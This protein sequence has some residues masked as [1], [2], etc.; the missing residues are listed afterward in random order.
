M[1]N[2]VLDHCRLTCSLGHKYVSYK[3]PLRSS[4]EDDAFS[5]ELCFMFSDGSLQAQDA[6]RIARAAEQTG[7]QAPEASKIAQCGIH[8]AQRNILKL[9][10]GVVD[11]YWIVLLLDMGTDG[12]RIP[13][14]CAALNMYEMFAAFHDAG[15][16]Q[17]AISMLGRQGIDSISEFWEAAGR[18]SVYKKHPALQQSWEVLKKMVPLVLFYDGAE[19]FR[20]K[21]YIWFIWSSAIAQASDWDC[22]IPILCLP[23]AFVKDNETLR[24]MFSEVTRFI[25]WNL[26]ILRSGVGA[27]KGFYD[28]ELKTKSML[29]LAGRQLANGFTACFA[30]VTGDFKAKH[31]WQG[32]SRYYRC[33]HLCEGCLAQSPTAKSDKRFSAYN[34]CHDAPWRGTILSDRQIEL[35]EKHVL[36]LSELEGWTN[37]LF[38]RDPMHMH[39]LGE[40]KDSTASSII[41]M[42]DLKLL[43]EGPPDTVL[44]RLHGKLDSYCNDNGLKRVAAPMLSLRMLNRADSSQT[45]PELSSTWKAAPTSVLIFFVA[46]ITEQVCTHSGYERLI[47]AH[48]WGLADYL[49]VCKRA[50]VELNSREQKRA[51][52]AGRVY[53]LTLQ[54]LCGIALK[55]K[56]FLWRCR[57]KNHQFDHALETM[58]TSALNPNI[59]TC[60]RKESMLGKLKRVGRSCSRLTVGAITLKKYAIHM[61]CRFRIRKRTRKWRVNPKARKVP[62]HHRGAD[63]FL[64]YRQFL[65]SSMA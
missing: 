21:E 47:A 63:R 60:L 18:S 2:I 37:E 9:F 17:F 54:A 33:R 32:Y 43:G 35:A 23:A 19:V 34:F 13:V 16:Q 36:P 28:E 51:L 39:L 49:F 62:V 65:A 48:C 26:G 27:L 30:A 58:K 56:L 1:P 10:K 64:S 57:P 44:A 40:G 52:H 22:E 25:K 14:E 3:H 45:F 4:L 42:V 29:A 41:S 7:L 31:E 24:L 53:L 46:H 38:L 8:H 50:G 6:I 59:G 20:D 55:N 15:E 12:E 11:V 61:K 5:E